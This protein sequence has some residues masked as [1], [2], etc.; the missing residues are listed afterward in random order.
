MVSASLCEGPWYVMR[1]MTAMCINRLNARSRRNHS[2]AALWSAGRR[3]RGWLLQTDYDR[4]AQLQRLTK[5]VSKQALA[6]ISWYTLMKLIRRRNSDTSDVGVWPPQNAVTESQS[7]V[8]IWLKASSSNLE[9]P[10]NKQ[11]Y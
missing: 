1:C 11:I 4:V 8:D 3:R 7:S 2:R 10:T 9:S 5:Y 6:A